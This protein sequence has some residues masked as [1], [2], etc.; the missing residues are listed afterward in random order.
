[1]LYDQK[2]VTARMFFREAIKRAMHEEMARDPRIFIMGQDVGAF[3][4]SYREFDGLF[5][6]F[7]PERV[8]DTPVAE[9]ATIGIAAGAAAAGYRPVVSITYMDFLMLGFDA[10]INYGA[11]LRYKSAG[12]LNAPL[13]VKTT[14]G[15]AGQGV[16]HSQCI[17]AWLMSV[18]GL[19]V[20]AA[21]TPEDA[22]GLMKT[23]LRCDGPVVY[24][25]HKRLFPIPGDVPVSETAIP[26]GVACVRRAGTDLTLVSHGYM[27]RP[28]LEA[29]EIVAA[30]GI[31]CEVIDLR[32]LAP[33]DVDT[34][35]A[36]VARTGRLLTLEEGQTVCGVGTE[37]AYRTFERTGPMPW[38]R[39]GALPAPVSSNPVLEAACIPDAARV[40]DAMR[41][42][43]AR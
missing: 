39:L 3:G 7:G 5:A 18:P 42:L 30:E 29:A 40:A 25:D 43:S 32:S 2:P 6:L 8:R 33:M 11:K 24:I 36:S 9:A 26:F 1:M 27:M 21:S 12:G 17:E 31:S 37:V 15:A 41:A 14:A 13:V 22:Y 10:L 38:I 4:G 19:R 35:A 34:L 28:A 16:A 20:V 23:A